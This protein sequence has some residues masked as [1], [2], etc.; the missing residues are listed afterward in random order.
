[1]RE[2]LRLKADARMK[3]HFKPLTATRLDPLAINALVLLFRPAILEL[4]E[5]E[6]LVFEARDIRQGFVKV[7]GRV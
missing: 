5:L 7:L 6:T 3:L 4:V 2:L 1:M